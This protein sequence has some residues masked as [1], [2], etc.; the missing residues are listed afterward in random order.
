MNSTLRK[1]GYHE[2]GQFI[3]WLG[4]IAK[5]HCLDE[6]RKNEDKEFVGLFDEEGNDYIPDE[7]TSAE[8][9]M[10]QKDEVRVLLGMLSE[11]YRIV[12]VKRYLEEKSVEET[13]AELGI[14]KNA[15]T[16]SL[17]RALQILRQKGGAR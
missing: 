13:A 1:H 15:V 16:V 11:N 12:V 9:R 3:H 17:S 7:S 2:E 5:C 14:T 4:R 10:M 6:L 8:E